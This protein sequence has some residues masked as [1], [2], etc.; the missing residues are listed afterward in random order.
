MK[1]RLSGLTAI[2]AF[3]LLAAAGYVAAM[4]TENMQSWD[5]DAPFRELVSV[6]D[7]FAETT[8]PTTTVRAWEAGTATS[9][10]MRAKTRGSAFNI[11][12]G[13]PG[14]F[15]WPRRLVVAGRPPISMPMGDMIYYLLMVETRC[16]IG[17]VGETE[18]TCFV[19]QDEADSKT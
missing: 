5:G 6:A 11:T 16:R 1:F 12:V 14:S 7:A 2:S 10:L 15:I 17:G 3:V 8:Q 18:S 9:R 13:Q 4:L 19:R